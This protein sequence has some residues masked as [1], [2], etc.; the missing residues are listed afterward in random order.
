MYLITGRRDVFLLGEDNDDWARR[1]IDD[2]IQQLPFDI[3]WTGAV[4][5]FEVDSKKTTE[6]REYLKFF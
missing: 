5:N 3:Y 4:T 6:L 2:E 1:L